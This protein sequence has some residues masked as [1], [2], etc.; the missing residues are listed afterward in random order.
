MTHPIIL[1]GLWVVVAFVMAAVP[2]KD[3]HWRRAYILLAIGLPLLVWIIWQ[4]GIWYGLL[5]LFIGGS[6]LRWPV[7]CLWRWVRQKMVG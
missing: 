3:N 7:Y 4:N 2:S 5:G 1:I 6:V